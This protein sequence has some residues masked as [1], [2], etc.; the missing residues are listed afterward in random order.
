MKNIPS[1]CC[2][3]G[4]GGKTFIPTEN[5]SSMGRVKGVPMRFMRGHHPTTSLAEYLI[6]E[7]GCWVW[8]RHK[9]KAG[10]GT[11]RRKGHRYAHRY[12]YELHKGAIPAGKVVCH[13]CDNPSCVNP[14]HLQLGDQK[15]NIK[16]MIEKGR[17]PDYAKNSGQGES[18]SRSK[19]TEKQVLEMRAGFDPE[20]DTYNSFAAIYGV[21]PAHISR[22]LRRVDWKHLQPG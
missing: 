6:N 16:D 13:K 10:Y 15:E 4:C 7:S 9:N 11:I 17:G 18:H 14:D 5:D 20:K 19:L 2:Q 3:C 8:Q 21:S 1:G 22:I 12:F